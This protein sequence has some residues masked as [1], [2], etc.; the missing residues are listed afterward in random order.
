MLIKRPQKPHIIFASPNIPNP[1]VYL[2]L[3]S[4]ETNADNRLR[5]T[6][7]PVAQIKFQIDLNTHTISACNDYAE[8]L[9]HLSTIQK[10][11]ATLI[12]FLR[13]FEVVKHKKITLK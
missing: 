1:E 9:I 2:R 13:M 7:S 10:S 6:F 11:D 5:S 4:E 12:D 3:L 8:E